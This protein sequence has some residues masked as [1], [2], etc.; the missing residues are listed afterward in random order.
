MTSF[1]VKTSDNKIIIT[2]RKQLA[3]GILK[4]KGYDSSTAWRF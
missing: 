4:I 1:Y 2:S 3:Q